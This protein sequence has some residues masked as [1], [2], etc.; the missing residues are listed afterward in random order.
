MKPFSK[1]IKRVPM[2]CIIAVDNCI[3]DTGETTESIIAGVTHE[4]DMYAEDQD[5]CIS[6]RE[7][8]ECVNYLRWV[9]WDDR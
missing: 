7:R 3:A 8:N 4:L 9:M 2:C 6:A 5:G 1:A